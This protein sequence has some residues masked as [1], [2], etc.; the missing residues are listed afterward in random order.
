[1][2][3]SIIMLT[4][5]Q[6][7]LTLDCVEGLYRH[8]SA[9]FELIC[10]DNGSRDGTVPYLQSLESWRDNVRLVINDSN[11]GFP[12]GVN[13]GLRI[14]RGDYIVLL[15]NDVVVAPYWEERMRGHLDRD[16]GLGIIGSSTNLCGNEAMIKETRYRSIE[17]MVQFAGA[18]TAAHHGEVEE[19]PMLGFYCVMF[20]RG[21][22][23]EIGMLDERFSPGYFEDDDYCVRARRHGYK[24]VVARDV[25]VHH[26]HQGTFRSIISN[27]GNIVEHGRREFEEK[28][29]V[30]VVK[31]HDLDYTYIEEAIGKDTR[32]II[33]EQEIDLCPS[34]TSTPSLG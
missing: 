4:H 31:A 22:L 27:P 24:L 25:F 14:A 10:V 12:K 18:Y 8:T 5:N 33:E 6:L 34:N 3:T 28:W 29:G 7:H 2:T 11:L 23:A 9:P 20:R 21:L 30:K 17:E 15:S 26:A 19:L 13:Q 16:P 1:M 32:A